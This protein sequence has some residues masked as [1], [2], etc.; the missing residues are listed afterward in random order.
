MEETLNNMNVIS[1]SSTDNNNNVPDIDEIPS[2]N[3]KISNNFNFDHASKKE[4]NES[5]EKL[6]NNNNCNIS[7]AKSPRTKKKAVQASLILNHPFRTLIFSPYASENIFMKHLLQTYKGLVYAKKC[8]KGQISDYQREK[9]VN[10][11][12]KKGFLKFLYF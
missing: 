6:S 11:K 4:D 2:T 3:K 8:L 7:P 12:E 1:I 9:A 5:P 10:L